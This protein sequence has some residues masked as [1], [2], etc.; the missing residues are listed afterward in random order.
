MFYSSYLHISF[1]K[2]CIQSNAIKINTESY[3]FMTV[4]SN[5][6]LNIMN[7]LFIHYNTQF[8]SLMDLFGIDYLDKSLR[9]QVV[10]NLISYFTYNRIY[11][12]IW[13]NELSPISS[14]T[15]IYPEANWYE[16]ECWDLYGIFFKNH[17][18]LRRILTD[19]GFQGHPFR[20]D[21]PLSGFTELRYDEKFQRI[22]YEPI[23]SI[24]EFR[25][26]D[27]LTPWEFY[28]TK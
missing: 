20:K 26:F 14:I 28:I 10:Y 4:H 27:S 24:Q 16:R 25:F 22:S 9:F 21:F 7:I 11:L 23:K 3:I 5:S 18:D 6:L 13:T 2:Y 19:Y 1:P 17:G 15:T 8:K 12:K